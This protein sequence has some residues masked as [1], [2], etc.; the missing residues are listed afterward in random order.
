[1]ANL[2]ILGESVKP[3]LLIW[4]ASTQKIILLFIDISYAMHHFPS[5]ILSS[6]WEG[7]V[8]S[9]LLI[10]QVIKVNCIMKTAVTEPL[11]HWHYVRYSVDISASVAVKARDYPTGKLIKCHY[12]ILTTVLP[13]LRRR[14]TWHCLCFSVLKHLVLWKVTLNDQL[15]CKCAA[16]TWSD[17]I[18]KMLSP[19]GP[20]T[21]WENI[22]ER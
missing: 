11:V 12:Q 6:N 15:R 16:W 13:R 3:S 2:T 9:M 20:S 17:N 7:K 4:S 1:M 14:R 19:R 22:T 8:P 18:Y 10:N 21:G 5:A